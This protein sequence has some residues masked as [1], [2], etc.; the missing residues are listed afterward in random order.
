MTTDE[1]DE[2]ELD[3]YEYFNELERRYLL[4]LLLAEKTGEEAL[5]ERLDGIGA[6][7]EEEEDRAEDDFYAFED[8]IL[9]LY[10]KKHGVIPMDF[11]ESEDPDLLAL[12]NRFHLLYQAKNLLQGEDEKQELIEFA[13]MAIAQLKEDFESGIDQVDEKL[14]ALEDEFIGE[15]FE[16]DELDDEEE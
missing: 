4:T 9:A 2:Y 6:R 7:L 5:M 1:M 3:E 16:D 11:P 10:A 8:E 12:K 14:T 13:S 15:F